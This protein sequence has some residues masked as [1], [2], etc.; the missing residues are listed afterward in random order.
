MREPT[1]LGS[2]GDR[3]SSH[4][5]FIRCGLACN[6]FQCRLPPVMTLNELDETISQ[7]EARLKALRLE[8][9]QLANDL[10]AAKAFRD[11]FPR[12]MIEQPGPLKA[13]AHIEQG[14]L[15]PQMELS[16]PDLIRDAIQRCGIDYNLNEV[17]KA[18]AEKGEIVKRLKITQNR[19]DWARRG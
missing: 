17:E 7:H 1:W 10:A 19:F 5:K 11:A 4:Y 3:A 13:P 18:L 16:V 12:L 2:K 8:L 14:P 15:I 9:N 6:G